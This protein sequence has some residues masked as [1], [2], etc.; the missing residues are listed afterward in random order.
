MW[1][2]SHASPLLSRSTEQEPTSGCSRCN[3]KD[4]ALPLLGPAHPPT[5]SRPRRTLASLRTTHL[6]CNMKEKAGGCRDAWV[7]GAPSWSLHSQSRK[8]R[9]QASRPLAPPPRPLG[10]WAPCCS[11]LRGQGCTLAPT[12]HLSVLR[13]DLPV[14][15]LVWCFLWFCFFFFF[16]LAAILK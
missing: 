10:I 4:L 6:K 1:P 11:V 7:S 14:L 16:C 8:G 12:L 3:A 9:T 13:P 15:L 2:S 5:A